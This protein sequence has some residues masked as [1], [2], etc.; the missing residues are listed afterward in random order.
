MPLSTDLQDLVEAPS[1]ATATNEKYEEPGPAEMG[2][3][4]VRIDKNLDDGGHAEK[5]EC[6]KTGEKSKNQ[7]YRKYMLC[8]GGHRR[9]EFW[10]DQ[11]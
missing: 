10:G 7:Q 9:S 1:T 3:P 8:V 2:R 5:G 4:R 11:G 6:R